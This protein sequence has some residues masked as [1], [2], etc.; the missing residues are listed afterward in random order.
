MAILFRAR[1]TGNTMYT[2]EMGDGITNPAPINGNNLQAQ[3]A[4]SDDGYLWLKAA[5]HYQQGTVF[6]PGSEP[7]GPDSDGDG[8]TDAE[9]LGPNKAL[10]GQRDPLNFWEFLDFTGDANVDLS[11]ALAVLDKFGCNPGDA[12]YDS[13]LDR[14]APDP[15][16]PR[17]SAQATDGIDLTDAL[18]NLQQFGHSCSAPP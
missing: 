13:L 1:V 15:Q 10:G 5:Q 12:C 2:D 6:L 8:C 17:R 16:K 9:E 4:D 3:Y 11:D 7:S 18:V 14:N